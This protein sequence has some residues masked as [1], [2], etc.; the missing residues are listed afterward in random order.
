MRLQL[1]EKSLN[2]VSLPAGKPQLIVWDE[3]VPGFGVVIG[4]RISTFIANYLANGTKRRQVIARRGQIRDD[5][6]PWTVTLARQRARE[7]LGKVAG[8]GDPSLELRKRQGGPTLGD[9]F[10]LHV[11]RSAR[12]KRPQQASRRLPASATSTSRSGSTVRWERSNAATV[13]HC[14]ST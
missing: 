1:T 6:E 7:I 3:E 4:R 14:T 13:G 5:G 12:G 8:G 10:D 9:A 11:S 2:K